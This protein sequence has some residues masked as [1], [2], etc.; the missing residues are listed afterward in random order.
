MTGVSSEVIGYNEIGAIVAYDMTGVIVVFEMIG[1]IEHAFRIRI[2]MCKIII[3]LIIA[4][5]TILII[6]KPT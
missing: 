1:A 5:M 3:I 2:Q 6:H 4:M